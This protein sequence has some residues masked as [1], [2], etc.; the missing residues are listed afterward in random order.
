MKSELEPF[1][2]P[3][4]PPARAP[5]GAMS[6]RATFLKEL[7]RLREHAG[8]SR[9]ELAQRLGVEERTVVR[10]ETGARCVSV[11]ELQIWVFACGSTLE[12][13]GRRLQ[14]HDPQ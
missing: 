13:F 8:L 3:S 7:I 6:A 2:R 4:R 14:A 1:E 5:A 11:I 12:E 9:R 10:G